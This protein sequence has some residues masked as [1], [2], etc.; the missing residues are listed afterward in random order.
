M[1]QAMLT[2]WDKAAILLRALSPGPNQEVLS[3][4][5]PAQAAQLQS[6]MENIAKRPD[7]KQITQ[8]VLREFQ[9]LRRHNGTP[10]PTKPEA[11]HYAANWIARQYS[12]TAA[13][14]RSDDSSDV[15]QEDAAFAT[16]KLAGIAAP[17]LARVLQTEP[18][19]VLVLTLQELPSDHAASVLKLLPPEGRGAA[20]SM[21][22]AGINVSKQVSE[23][24][25]T[26]VLK[27]CSVAGP[28]KE[29]VPDEDLQVKRMVG[30]LQSVDRDERLRLMALLAEQNEVVAAKIDDSLYD[31]TD[32][33]RI[34]DRSLQKILTQTDQ[35][36]LAMALKTAPEGI[37]DK[38][39]KN[40]SE[41]VRAALAEEME[42]LSEVP[43]AKA[44]AARKEI[45]SIIR[46]QDKEGALVWLES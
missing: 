46:A 18:P 15:P 21:M 19:R 25:L 34:G 17:V 7:L 42:F 33:L 26:T 38:V 14:D 5:D 13:A 2:N 40:M 31:Y 30:I 32:L 10:E 16:S 3:S 23:C 8:D 39:L 9:E 45:T 35:K 43:N 12:E 29:S 1:T 20:I 24:V 6:V 41:R 44:E 36:T 22:A 11:P 4:L 37:R 28:A 27:Q